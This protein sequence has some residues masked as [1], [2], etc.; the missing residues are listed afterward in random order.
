MSR[1]SVRAGNPWHLFTFV[2]FIIGSTL[3]ARH[4]YPDERIVQQSQHQYWRKVNLK[5]TRGI[6][7][8]VKGNALVMTEALP[9][10]AID[11]SMIEQEDL[12][13]L[14][15]VISPDIMQKI[16]NAMGTKSLFMD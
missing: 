4:C 11:P 8:D 16:T 15:Q 13:E 10:F 12:P 14:A 6:I 2:F 7:Q 1:R 5:A 9:A 3:I